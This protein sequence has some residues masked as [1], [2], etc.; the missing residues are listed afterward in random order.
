MMR[1][2][3]IFAVY[4]V[5]WSQIQNKTKLGIISSLA[6]LKLVITNFKKVLDILFIVC[7]NCIIKRKE[8]NKNDDK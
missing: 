6:R 5:D 3:L 8:G 4:L 1:N 7:Y 2:G